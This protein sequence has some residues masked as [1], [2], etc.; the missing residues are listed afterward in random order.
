MATYACLLLF[1]GFKDSVF[2]LMTA[3][4]SKWQ[5]TITVFAFTFILP[6]LNIYLMYKLKRINSITLSN[7]HER[8]FPYIM[9]AIFYFGLFYLF[10]DLRIWETIKI[11][12]FCAGSAILLTALINL[13]YKISAHMVGI[14]G[15]VGMMLSLVIL[16]NYDLML[17]I[18][19]GVIASGLVGASRLYLK[20]HTPAQ[21]YLGFFLGIFCQFILFLPLQQINLNF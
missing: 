20:E 17:Y 5:I 15:I 14:G 19:L 4:A 16:L 13:K 11:F 8:T 9:T 1:F 2:E 6:A 3:T 12:V 21:V 10:F 7:Q 18:I